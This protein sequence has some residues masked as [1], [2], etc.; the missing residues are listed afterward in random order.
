MAII[1]RIDEI[2]E[3]P[4]KI[5]PE[6]LREIFGEILVLF[7]ELKSQLSSKEETVRE[8]ALNTIAEL[9][10]QIEEKMIALCQLVGMDPKSFETYISDP[11]HFNRHEWE[12]IERTNSE[13]ADFQNEL[14]DIARSG[15]IRNIKHN[16]YT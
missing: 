6:T 16:R 5:T 13:V 1:S 2:L 7:E 11:S 10:E 15:P 9:K 4:G 3:E 14:N 8:D 12:A